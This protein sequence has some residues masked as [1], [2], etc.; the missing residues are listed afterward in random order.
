MGVLRH[1]IPRSDVP[2]NIKY[3]RIEPSDMRVSM[4]D[5]KRLRRINPQDHAPKGAK[6]LGVYIPE[7]VLKRSENAK[8]K[9]QVQSPEE[10]NHG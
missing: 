6:L 7:H 5:G 1:G 4:F 9:Q 8:K 3:V 10:P 2:R